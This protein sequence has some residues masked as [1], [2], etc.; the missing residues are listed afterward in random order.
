MPDYAVTL[1]HEAGTCPVYDSKA[2]K[3]FQEL[4]EKRE[5]AAKKLKVRI[6]SKW[7]PTRIHQTYWIIEAP[8]R[9]VAEEYFK[10]VGLSIWNKVEVQEVKL[11]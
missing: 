3:E 2:M 10:A 11:V 5:E 7:S 8:S 9:E 1:T 4:S 6:I